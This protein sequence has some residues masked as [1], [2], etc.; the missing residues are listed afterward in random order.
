M[1]A[2]GLLWGFNDGWFDASGLIRM[3]RA[4]MP[5][6]DMPYGCLVASYPGQSLFYAGDRG[7]FPTQPVEVGH[8]LHF[9]LNMSAGDHAT[10][11]GSV[12]VT[13]IQVAAGAPVDNE[14]F[15]IT[16]NTPLPLSTG[17]VA[18]H[19]DDEFLVMCE[20][21]VKVAAITRPFNGGWFDPSGLTRLRRSGQPS[22]Y[23]YGCVIGRFL[24]SN[25]FYIGDHGTWYTQSVDI[26]DDL[27]L[28][29]NMSASDHSSMQGQFEVSVVRFPAGTVGVESPP[30]LG[31][32]RA[33]IDASPVPSRFATRI[34]LDLPV[35]GPVLARIYDTSG[36]WLRTLED[37]TLA[38]GSHTL[39][40]DLRDD[41]GARLPAGTYFCQV[42]LT[43][44]SL[45][46]KLV[47][48][49]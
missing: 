36:R 17:I 9:T 48:V 3:R 5:Y 24:G 19:M 29:L 2:A 23:S 13:A 21:V 18:D 30:L 46:R 11:L 43:D 34:E 42:S 12:V 40:W 31:D 1:Q 16:A 32:L 47:V 20:G 28:N 27:Q 22:D 10:M 45:T 26:G 38:A 25:Y 7:S 33:A 37:E 8:E 35:A 41:G 44:R 15:V 14:T 39:V 6:N 49:E 4:G